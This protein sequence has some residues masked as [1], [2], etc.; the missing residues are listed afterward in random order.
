MVN[1]K[2]I[3]VSKIILSI[4]SLGPLIWTIVLLIASQFY[5]Y[6]IDSFDFNSI[7]NSI[8]EMHWWCMLFYLRLGGFFIWLVVLIILSWRKQLSKKQVLIHVFLTLVGLLAAYIS[9]K[10]NVGGV[11]GYLD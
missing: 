11:L 6:N 1:S 3:R 9:I 7:K 4:L 2:V 8:K 10:Y 5:T